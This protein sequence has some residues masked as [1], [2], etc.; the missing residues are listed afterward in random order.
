[1][2]LL[3]KTQEEYY[4]GPDGNWNTLD[5]NYGYYQYI[6]LDDIVN[7]FIIA[8]VGED[9]VLSRIK[10]TDVAFHAQRGIAEL[11]FDTLRSFKSQEIEI[12]P[13]LNMIIPFD[14]INYV[15]VTW[16]GG[17]GVERTLFP[18]RKTSNPLPILQDDKYEYLFNEQTGEI[19]TAWE[20]ETKKIATK[21]G[22]TL[23][24]DSIEEGITRGIEPEN[25][26]ANGYFFIDELKGMIF[27]SSNVVGKIVTL[28]YISDGLATNEEIRIHKFAEDALYK[29][30][31]HAILST[32]ANTQEYIINRYK[33]EKIAARRTAKIRLSNIKTEEIAQ[34]IRNKSKKLKQ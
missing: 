31:I 8:Y 5:E 10:R 3:D 24:I 21:N 20:S 22:N 1:M 11:S 17:D 19:L 18:A 33:K 9:K 30:I 25:M 7:N 12:P 15:K 26:T 29:Y 6:G 4:Q 13:T 28:K 27:F 14:Y 34:V 2:A 32:R 16:T 23:N